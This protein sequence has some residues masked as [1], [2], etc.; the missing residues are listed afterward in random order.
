M[1][2]NP[3][4]IEDLKEIPEKYRSTIDND[5]FLL[6]DS[7]EDQ[8]ANR[9][10]KRIIIFATK[11]NLRQLMK[12]KIWF[13]DG[14]FKSAPSVFLQ[15]FTVL[16]SVTQ[17]VQGKEQT[18]ALPFVFSLLESKEESSY[19]KVF[20]ICLEKCNAFGINISLPSY[21]MSD[22]EKAIINAV[23]TNIGEDKVRLCFFHL[24]QTVFRRI[25][26]EG[27][28][29][30]YNHET[31]TTIRDASKKMCALACVPPE[32]VSE[33]FDLLVDEI[34]EAFVDVAEYFEKNYIRGTT[35][36]GR[37]RA[38]PPAYHPSLWN[39]Y[40]SIVDHTA[41][42]NNSS[43]GWHNRFQVLLNKNHPSLYHFLNELL[44][45][46]EDTE[47]LLRRLDLGQKIRRPQTPKVIQ[48]E[49]R[50]FNIATQF[51][52]YRT[53]QREMDYLQ[54]IAHNL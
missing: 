19:S 13:V 50:M 41:K 31:D 30:Q 29:E 6:Y 4:S 25:Q 51:E 20:E 42:T 18:F 9:P 5:P 46:Q 10:T 2:P 11:D 3:L 8:S 54:N 28:Q 12:S 37:R 48:N 17:I 23:K 22:F 14:T 38:V 27:L 7:Y 49:E 39:Q 45:E 16:G 21:V 1:P 33:Y 52:N 40:A 35:A 15:I 24:R 36:R 44:K 34:P 32:H 43:E 53:E 47:R 26:S